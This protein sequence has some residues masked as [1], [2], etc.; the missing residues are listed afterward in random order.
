MTMSPI[1]NVKMT[2]EQLATEDSLRRF[3][4]NSMDINIEID[5]MATD[6]ADILLLDDMLPLEIKAIVTMIDAVAFTLNNQVGIG[7]N[8]EVLGDMDKNRVIRFTHKGKILNSSFDG[9]VA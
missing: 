5:W 7:L 3:L 4:P 2:F 6:S 8:Y 9:V 1:Q